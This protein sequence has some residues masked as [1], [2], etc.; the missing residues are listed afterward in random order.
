MKKQINKRKTIKSLE[1]EIAKLR[2]KIKIHF[3]VE[4]SLVI[5]ILLNKFNII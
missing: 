2:K 4:L 3:L 1:W 5:T